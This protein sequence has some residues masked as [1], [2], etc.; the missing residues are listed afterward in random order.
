MK[1]PSIKQLPVRFSHAGPEARAD[2][3]GRFT[4]FSANRAELLTRFRIERGDRLLLSFELHGERFHERAAQVIRASTDMDGYYGAQLRF[5][6]V[7]TQVKLG[8]VLRDLL[9]HTP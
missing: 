7:T 3:W 2:G 6:S 9:S 5:Q 4:R 1:I 8:R